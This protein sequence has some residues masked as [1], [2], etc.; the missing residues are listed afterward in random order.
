MSPQRIQIRHLR[1]AN[2]WR[3]SISGTFQENSE[4]G[5][6]ARSEV[7]KRKHGLESA[8]DA[9]LGLSARLRAASS[10][11]CCARERPALSW[12]FPCRHPRPVA[13]LVA[14]LPSSLSLTAY[15]FSHSSDGE[16]TTKPPATPHA[17][18][19]R[20]GTPRKTDRNSKTYDIY[21]G[22]GSKCSVFSIFSFCLPLLNIMNFR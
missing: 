21:D 22:S 1:A 6:T 8:R 7:T 5:H 2:A 19:R 15:G 3:M 14:R 18:Y 11:R 17:F 9:V 13:L 16:I 12:L 20:I 10:D 4:G